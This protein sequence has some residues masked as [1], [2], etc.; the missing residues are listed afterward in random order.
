MLPAATRYSG[1]ILIAGCEGVFGE[2]ECPRPKGFLVFLCTGKTVNNHS[3]AKNHSYLMNHY[4]FSYS[5]HVASQYFDKNP[6][7]SRGSHARLS[8]SRFSRTAGHSCKYPVT[9]KRTLSAL[10]A[11]LHKGTVP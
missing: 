4:V 5:R 10:D 8:P 1:N 7:I 6:L 9:Y 11:Y 3:A 2:R